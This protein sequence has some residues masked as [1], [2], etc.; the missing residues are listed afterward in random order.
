M[1]KLP[2]KE[3]QTAE[4]KPS[5]DKE[6]IET[7][8]AFSNA[9]GG[10]VYIGF[11]DKGKIQGVTIGKESVQDLLSGNYVS[12]SRNKLIARAFKAANVIERYGS[13]IMRIRKICK[14]Y[15]VKEPN[16]EEIS[17]GFQVILYNEKIN[18]TDSNIDRAKKIIKNNTKKGTEKVSINQQKIIKNLLE[19]PS[20]TSEELSVIIGIRADKI[21]INLSKLKSKGLIER[22]GADKGG[23]WKVKT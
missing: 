13:G 23:Y 10:T 6:V 9:K 4:F 17:S 7:L 22:V 3:S 19:N 12:K 21:R 15:G 5:F 8:V 18:V 16:F 11:S 2:T 14:D 1:P 20:I